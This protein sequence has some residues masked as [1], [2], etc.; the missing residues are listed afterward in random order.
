[1]RY[2][3]G[4]AWNS[5]ERDAAEALER[6]ARGSKHPAQTPAATIGAMI[7]GRAWELAAASMMHPLAGSADAPSPR[8]SRADE[9]GAA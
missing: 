1:M 2:V 4:H 9:G 8:V 6:L 7:V 5:G 3:A